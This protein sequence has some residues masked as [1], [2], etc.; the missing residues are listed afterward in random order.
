MILYVWPG[1]WNLPSLDPECLTSMCY[2]KFCKIDH[3]VVTVNSPIDLFKNDYPR[4]EYKNEI[5]I[6]LEQILECI[7]KAKKNVDLILKDENYADELALL[8][9]FKQKFIPS[10][11]CLCWLDEDNTFTVIRRAYGKYVRFPLSLFKLK[12][13]AMKVENN[14]M[15]E[16]KDSHICYDNLK[17]QILNEG[18]EALNTIGVQLA[19]NVFMFENQ[20]SLIDAYLFGY[21]SILNHAPFVGSQLKTHLSAFNNL[22]SLI[23][24]IQ[25]DLFAGEIQIHNSTN[26]RRESTSHKKS[27]FSRFASL[28]MPPPSQSNRSYSEN[29]D[30]NKR[31][32]QMIAVV[33][34]L[35]AML[36]Y[37]CKIGLIK[38][39]LVKNDIEYFEN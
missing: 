21:L 31:K 35:T 20:P 16:F 18:K 12:K 33:I 39:A 27:K 9:L 8:C 13:M 29:E 5:Y 38:F 36:V 26:K 14:I 23:N 15:C 7:V 1:D 30:W 22:L 6:G 37:A 10:F 32:Q 34:T 25:K 11:N 4:L 24:R 19:E 28:F 3:K 17:L 2:L